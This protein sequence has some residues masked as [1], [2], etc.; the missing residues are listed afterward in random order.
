MAARWCPQ[1]YQRQG[2]GDEGSGFPDEDRLHCMYRQ[3]TDLLRSRREADRS[4]PLSVE[5]RELAVSAG[6]GQCGERCAH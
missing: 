2:G 3:G 5:E 6:C 1:A 4:G